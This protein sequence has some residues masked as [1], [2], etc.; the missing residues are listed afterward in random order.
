MLSELIFSSRGNTFIL[1][2]AVLSLPSKTLTRVGKAICGSHQASKYV[3][4]QVP[5]E[6]S[7]YSNPVEKRSITDNLCLPGTQEWRVIVNAQHNLFIIPADTPNH[8]T[9]FIFILF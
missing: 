4:T 9:D 5:T 7:Q 8:Y 1:T 6:M 2:P 3:L